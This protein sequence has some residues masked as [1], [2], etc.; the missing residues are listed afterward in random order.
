MHIF[1]FELVKSIVEN[2]RGVGNRGETNHVPLARKAFVEI[3]RLFSFV[4]TS[5]KPTVLERILI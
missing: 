2:Y 3:S 5:R 4:G 1:E